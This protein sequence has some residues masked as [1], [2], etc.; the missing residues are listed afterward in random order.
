MRKPLLLLP[1][2]FFSC[3]LNAQDLSAVK[4]LKQLWKYDEAI[5]AV[6]AMITQQGPRPDLLEELADC[7][8]Q[9]GNIGEALELY[10][11]LS[12]LLPDKVL[13]KLRLMSLLNR[14]QQF[15]AVISLGRDVLQ[16]DSIAQVAVM[17][18]DAFNKLERRDSA[19]WYYRR[20]L[21]RRSHNESV[22]NKLSNILLG[23]ERFNEVRVLAEDFLAEEP[24]N[25]TIL[26]VAGVAYF[27]LEDYNKAYD[28]FE[29][30]NKLGDDS[31]AVHYYLGKCA[32]KFG[33]RN[34][35]E[36]EFTLAWE[37]DSTDVG[38]ALTIARVKADLNRP[39]WETWYGKALDMLLPSPKLLETTGSAYQNYAHS[40]YMKGRFDSC[41]ELYKKV[42]EYRPKYYAAYYM[43]AQCYE[44]KYD[45]QN[46]LNWFKK[47][48]K[49]FAE[50]TRGREIAD[51]GAERVQAEIFMLGD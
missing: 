28:T 37:R 39:D 14:G 45:Y 48:Q 19:E 24:D 27:A 13:Y 30:V 51:A 46:A 44:Y 25:L 4:E 31:Y 26:P 18:G 17:V 33:I 6:S 43:I 8:Y 12:E 21:A 7:H 36:R 10:T 42:L 5:A 23:Q 50:G 49:V 20:V 32:Q 9:S 3:L 16:R 2:F 38:V 29:K 11:E 47:A 1:L 40:A 34:V 35:E 15:S 22:L 41:I